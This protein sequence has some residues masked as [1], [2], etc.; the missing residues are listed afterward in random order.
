MQCPDKFKVKKA[1]R[2]DLEKRLV[3][4]KNW[5]FF[6]IMGYTLISWGQS[7]VSKP[8][9]ILVPFAAGGSS[10]V[11]ARNLAKQLSDQ[12]STPF[13]IENKPGGGGGVAMEVVARSIPDGHTLLYGTIGTNGVA[14]VLF[15]NFPIDP[16]KDL[17]PISILAF[18]PSVLIVNSGLPIK[19][20]KEFIAYAKSNP[21]KLT[22]ASAGN[23]SISHLAGELLK[24]SAN[25]DVVHIPYKG[26][27]A[28]VT[29]LLSGNVSFMIETITN[30]L[31]LVQTGKMRAI[32]ITSGKPWASAPEIPTFA[33]SGLPGF[34][35]DSWTGLFAP[36]ATP[37]IIVDRLNLE[38]V[39]TLQSENY[40]KSMTAIGVE[41]SSSSPEEF[42]NFVNEE[43][44]KWSKVIKITGTKID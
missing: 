32:A 30:S 40:K 27:G 37:R 29:D 36:I 9:R 18:N 33:Q 38:I 10:D 42:S 15:K 16:I 35:V 4:L 6:S 20:L 21:G 14:P 25:I 44:N 13:V 3:C 26:G 34:E 8:Y 24:T 22:Y 1:N 12:M 41:P 19:S 11:M 7:N 39:K 5:L 23:G 17:Q 43:L 31:N 28:A 2:L